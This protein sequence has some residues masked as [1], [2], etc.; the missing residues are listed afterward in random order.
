MK[1]LIR[2]LLVI[3][4]FSSC[5]KDD[6]VQLKFAPSL[7][8]QPEYIWKW[9][10]IDYTTIHYSFLTEL[11]TSDDYDNPDIYNHSLNIDL[12]QDFLTINKGQVC[13]IKKFDIIS[14]SGEVMFYIPYEGQPGSDIV[15]MKLPLSIP[16]NSSINLS[17]GVIR[18]PMQ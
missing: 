16:M 2:L 17:I 11:K 8:G 4:L 3:A 9:D 18:Y 10:S 7:V 13:I 15:H 12:K 6:S 14:R 1:K 5:K